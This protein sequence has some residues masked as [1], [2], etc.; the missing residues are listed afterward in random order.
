M[1][2]EIDKLTGIFIILHKKYTN[3]YKS[4][5][6]SHMYKTMDCLLC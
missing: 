5:N 1:N 3:Y 6:L 2:K 4:D